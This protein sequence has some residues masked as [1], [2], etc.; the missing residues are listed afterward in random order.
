MRFLLFFSDLLLYV[1][2]FVLFVNLCCN[3]HKSPQFTMVNV[4]TNQK[5]HLFAN[6]ETTTNLVHCPNHHFNRTKRCLQPQPRM[7]QRSTPHKANFE[8]TIL[9]FFQFSNVKTIMGNALS[10]SMSFLIYSA[11]KFQ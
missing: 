2:T 10:H 6:V 4:R 9:N 7:F 8:V 5:T 11:H 3:V 1:A